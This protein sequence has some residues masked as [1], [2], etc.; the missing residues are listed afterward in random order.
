MNYFRVLSLGCHRDA[1][2]GLVGSA[3]H[4]DVAT[5]HVVVNCGIVLM[6][7]FL[8]LAS[9]TEIRAIAEW[10]SSGLV[11]NRGNNGWGRIG[12]RVE[13]TGLSGEFSAA[14]L[15]ALKPSPRTRIPPYLSSSIS[16]AN[17]S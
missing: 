12:S 1:G 14:L 9:Y 3:A 7:G 8:A 17:S 5:A 2:K 13:A 6:A 16:F 15:A 10:S 4:D 11:G